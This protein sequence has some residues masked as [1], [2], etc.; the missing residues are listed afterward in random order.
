MPEKKFKK[1]HVSKV[2]SSLATTVTRVAWFDGAISPKHPDVQA[3]EGAENK[4]FYFNDALIRE[5]VDHDPVLVKKF[6]E[7]FIPKICGPACQKGL[8]PITEIEMKATQNINQ[9][10]FMDVVIRYEM[11]IKG[12]RG[13]ARILVAEYPSA[14]GR[15]WLCIP[16]QLLEKG[17]HQ[18][19][20]YIQRQAKKIIS[21]PSLTL[22]DPVVIQ[23]QR[24]GRFFNQPTYVDLRTRDFTNDAPNQFALS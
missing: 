9:T 1:L 7:D 5:L 12:D 23:P 3:I 18:G 15:S 8:K 22:Q 21:A 17:I 2:K 11:K 13:D 4:Y 19:D 6:C 20:A 16:I 10:D 24:H 14:D